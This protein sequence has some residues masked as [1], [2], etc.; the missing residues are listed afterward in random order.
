LKRKR[1]ETEEDDATM[2]P[3]MFIDGCGCGID[4]D[5]PGVCWM[6]PFASYIEFESNA[7]VVIAALFQFT[8]DCPGFYVD[9]SI[10]SMCLY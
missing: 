8:G 9:A 5:K 6:Y 4:P 1:D 3:C 7:T 2:L 10:E